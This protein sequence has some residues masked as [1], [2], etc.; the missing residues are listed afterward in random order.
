MGWADSVSDDK[1]DDLLAE[2][3]ARLKAGARVEARRDFW[4]QYWPKIVA[5]IAALSL[6]FSVGG[7]VVVTTLWGRQ[8]ATDAS[9]STLRAE[10][11]QYKAAG[12]AANRQLE[13]RGQSPVPIPS[14]GSTDDINVI[15]A[16]AT[17]KVL[18]SLPDLHPTA[19]Q[20]GQ[21]VAQYMAAN[22]VTPAAPTPGQ[23]S[24][25]LAGYLATN[26][27]PSGPSGPPGPSG[28]AG[29]T[30][31]SGPTGQQGPPGPQ[32]PQGDPG[33]APTETQIQTAFEDYIQSHPSALCPEGGSFGEARIQLA[34]GSSADT[35][36]CIVATYPAP[37]TTS[38]LLPIPKV[39]TK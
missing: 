14:P 19:A 16:S 37:T 8:N 3:I 18:A 31:E 35:W 24:A 15:V 22:P 36:T 7:A 11:E 28:A 17:A 12:D 9:V 10:A 13:Q 4:H 21:A 26:P 1:P 34:D 39:R 32:G 6:L 5:A 25:A 20:L 30:G 27:P 29:A 38:D 33:P 2:G 23:I